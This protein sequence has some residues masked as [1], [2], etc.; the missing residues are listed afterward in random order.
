VRWDSGVEIGSNVTLYYDSLLAK[1]IVWASDRPEAIRRMA[2]ALDELVI[3]GVSTN[4]SFHARLLADQ[5]FRSGE[6]DIQFLERRSDLLA[7]TPDQAL[8]LDLAIAVALAEQE[9]RQTRRQV[10]T[11]GEPSA[12][13][14]WLRQARLEALQ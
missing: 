9:E 12:G 1:L 2:R 7:G 4:Q 10:V 8:D 3:V 5:A 13:G 11:N 14:A 6:I